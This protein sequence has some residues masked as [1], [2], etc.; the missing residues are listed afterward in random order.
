MAFVQWNI[1]RGDLVKI[2]I[3]EETETHSYGV[4]ISE[5]PYEHQISLFPVVRVFSFARGHE[6][7]YY[8]Y[9]LEVLSASP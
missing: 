2:A 8:P 9:N 3:S 1:K 5:E 6:G 7:E 4:V